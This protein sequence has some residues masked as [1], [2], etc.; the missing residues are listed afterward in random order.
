M[1]LLKMVG[2]AKRKAIEEFR[3]EI[4]LKDATVKAYQEM[5]ARNLK[6]G[7][8]D[9]IKKTLPKRNENLWTKIKK[10]FFKILQ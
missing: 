6:N 1:I 10:N 4:E 5:L 2:T 9:E 7:M 3:G 8:G